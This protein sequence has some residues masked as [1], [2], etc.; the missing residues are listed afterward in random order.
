MSAWRT[1]AVES[2]AMSTFVRVLSLFRK[3][4]EDTSGRAKESSR[5]IPRRAIA[6]LSGRSSREISERAEADEAL[7]RLADRSLP[8][9]ALTRAGQVLLTAWHDSLCG[10]G[11]SRWRATTIERR[12]RVTAFVLLIAA[13]T[14]IAVTGFRAPEPTV[15]ARATWIAILAVLA[16]TAVEARG[17]AAAWISWI[18]RSRSGAHELP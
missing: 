8:F 3:K 13:I 12:V 16:M 11:L 18:T 7:I 14:H 10:A 5:G 2:V 1:M 9:R 6:E 17:V 15:T 4:L